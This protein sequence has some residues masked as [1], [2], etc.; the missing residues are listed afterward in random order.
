MVKDGLFY[1]TIVSI[2]NRFPQNKSNAQPTL[3]C[4]L[5]I[6]CRAPLILRFEVFPLCCRETFAL[7]P[8]SPFSDLRSMPPKP[9]GGKAQNLTVGSDVPTALL[10]PSD[11]LHIYAEQKKPQSEFVLIRHAL[12][13]E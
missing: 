9:K 7:L 4:Y 5:H 6:T 13:I 12:M 1:K 11:Y 2:Q 8:L 3:H 10:A